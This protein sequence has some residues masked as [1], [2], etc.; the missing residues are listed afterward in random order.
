MVYFWVG[1]IKGKNNF[2]GCQEY[3]CCQYRSLIKTNKV[4]YLFGLDLSQRN[5]F[6][7]PHLSLPFHR[8]CQKFQKIYYESLI[9]LN[10]NV[11]SHLAMFPVVSVW[12]RPLKLEQQIKYCAKRNFVLFSKENA[13]ITWSILSLN[14][15]KHFVFTI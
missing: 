3:F 15:W 13:C 6:L 11:C 10:K 9:I 4:L 1:E 2:F 12:N 5:T 7:I 8:K 14:T